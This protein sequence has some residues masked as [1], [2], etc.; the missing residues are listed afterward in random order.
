MKCESTSGLAGSLMRFI[1]ED[2]E[3]ENLPALL[4]DSWQKQRRSTLVCPEVHL[5]R[6]LALGMGLA[7]AK[8]HRRGT[9]CT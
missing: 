7:M 8:S 3:P 1:T 2:P 9:A 6:T 5:S 4:R